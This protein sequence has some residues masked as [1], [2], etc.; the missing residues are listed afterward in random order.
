MNTTRSSKDTRRIIEQSVRLCKTPGFVYNENDNLSSEGENNRSAIKDSIEKMNQPI[1]PP[2]RKRKRPKAGSKSSSNILTYETFLQVISAI[3]LSVLKEDFIFQVWVE[4]KDEDEAYI[5]ELGVSRMVVGKFVE[6]YM[7]PFANVLAITEK[8]REVNPSK[9][10]Y[11]HLWDVLFRLINTHGFELKLCKSSNEVCHVTQQ[12][13]KGSQKLFTLILKMHEMKKKNV[14]DAIDKKYHVIE[15]PVYFVLSE[16]YAL[17]SLAAWY[18]FFLEQL[19]ARNF[20][21]WFTMQ[22]KKDKNYVKNKSRSKI[23]ND[24]ITSHEKELK[25][26]FDNVIFYVSILK[27]DFRQREMILRQIEKKTK[28]DFSMK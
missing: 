5:D 18:T 11:A 1:E 23:I 21:D 28:Q 2:T 17:L 9:S 3:I 22:R 24:F 14:I 20:L 25:S 27:R 26:V 13:P 10:E 15:M 4:G 16:K 8:M 19:I 12:S 7:N 6:E